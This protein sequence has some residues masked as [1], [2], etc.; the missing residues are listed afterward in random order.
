[1]MHRAAQSLSE[2]AAEP[3]FR[4]INGVL[5]RFVESDDLPGFGRS[6]RRDTLRT[7][8]LRAAKKVT[9]R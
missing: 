6:E 5:M 2:I 1:M 9:A 7:V 4:T 3:A 8:I